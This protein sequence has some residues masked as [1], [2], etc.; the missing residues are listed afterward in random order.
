MSKQETLICEERADAGSPAAKRLRAK[1]RVPAVLYGAKV[2]PTKLHLEQKEISRLLNHAAGE[3]LLVDLEI[4]SEKGKAAKHT[5]LI[6]QVQH[7]PV[8]GNILHLDFHAISM[9]EKL[10]AEIPLQ[11]VGEAVGVKNQG[12]ILE[13]G[14]R[15]LEVEC[16]P[17]DLPD[18]IEVDISA[19]EVGGSIHIGGIKLPEG[20]TTTADP[21]VTAF[22]VSPPRVQEEEETAAEEAAE[23]EL[24][25]KKDEDEAGEEKKEAS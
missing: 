17:K 16:L 4:R 14:V 18:L 5:A 20:V 13:Q 2:E 23:P 21:E 12:G 22:I 10:T 24:I 3:S 7:H 11:P 19:L 25:G 15:S 1:G 9:T 6:Q 8:S